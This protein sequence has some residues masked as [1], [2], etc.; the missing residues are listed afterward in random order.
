MVLKIICGLLI[1]LVLSKASPNSVTSS[2]LTTANYEVDNSTLEDTSLTTSTDTLSTCNELSD[3]N[4]TITELSTTPAPK[5]TSKA[6]NKNKS[7]KKKF[8]TSSRETCS[9]NLKV[10]ISKNDVEKFS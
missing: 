7:I 4:A 2:T 6:T 3:C 1:A 10:N 8:H 9:C 5:S